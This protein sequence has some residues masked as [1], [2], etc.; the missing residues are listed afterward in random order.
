MTVSG[1]RVRNGRGKTEKQVS[2]TSTFGGVISE[3]KQLFRSKMGPNYCGLNV[4]GP[5]THSEKGEQSSV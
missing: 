4:S 3:P 5:H 1:G 2:S